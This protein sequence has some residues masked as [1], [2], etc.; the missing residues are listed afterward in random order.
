[1]STHKFKQLNNDLVNSYHLLLCCINLIYL[2]V[3][4]LDDDDSELKNYKK[5][6]LLVKIAATAANMSKP[7]HQASYNLLF[8][9]YLCKHFDGEP[10]ETKTIN[11]H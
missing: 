10:I 4:P 8:I 3:K 5:N 2:N 1:M 6:L 11:E 7:N 9:D